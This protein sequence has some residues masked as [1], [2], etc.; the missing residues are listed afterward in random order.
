[1]SLASLLIAF[2]PIYGH[3]ISDNRCY[4]QGFR[5][6]WTL[7]VEPRFLVTVAEGLQETVVA[8]LEVGFRVC[9]LI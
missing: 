5:F 4:F 6:L 1:M 2:F 7:A 8:S 3:S 9:V